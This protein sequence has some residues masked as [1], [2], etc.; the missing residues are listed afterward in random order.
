MFCIPRL[1]RILYYKCKFAVFL[2]LN[3][4]VLAQPSFLSLA[5][6]LALSSKLRR[7]QATSTKG[8]QALSLRVRTMTALL[9]LL[10]HSHFH[11]FLLTISWILKLS[12]RKQGGNRGFCERVAQPEMGAYLEL[13]HWSL[14]SNLLWESPCVSTRGRSWQLKSIRIKYDS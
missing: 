12:L 9:G 3:C 10:T 2:P 1:R 7:P 13:P 8:S 5:S 11:H 4:N 6:G 14:W